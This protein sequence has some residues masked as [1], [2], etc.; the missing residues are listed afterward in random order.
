MK[1]A[2]ALRE[3][4]LLAR[5]TQIPHADFLYLL[6]ELTGLNNVE[7]LLERATELTDAQD[8]QWQQFSQRRVEGEPSQ[9][10][11]GKAYFYGMELSVSPAVLIPRP[12]TE[13]LVELILQRTYPG[14]RVLDIGTG[15]G[16]IALA[17]K[18][19]RPD[20]ELTAT[21]ISVH[22]IE[23][24]RMNAERLGL[25]IDFREAD[26]FPEDGQRFD[27]IVSN[28]P[29]ISASDYALLPVHI[30]EHEPKTALLAEEDGL[31]YYRRILELSS[32]HT[33]PGAMIC[34]EIGAGQSEQIKAIAKKQGLDRIEIKRDPAGLDR[35]VLI[36]T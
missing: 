32:L 11:I 19:I 20:L 27:L 10:I 15:S 6:S 30:R 21:D 36:N 12:E 22:S 14:Q 18:L 13:G 1:L 23:V 2:D 34:F 26:L 9:Y 29:Y 8:E 7:L 4:E 16:A 25:E 3:A 17:L 33:N 5:S 28:P 24:A 31:V 35:Y